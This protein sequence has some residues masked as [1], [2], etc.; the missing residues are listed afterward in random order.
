MNILDWTSLKTHNTGFLATWLRD[1]DDFG[2][3]PFEPCH[4]K[5]NN[6]VSAPHKHRRWLE[7]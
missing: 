3:K 1:I 2:A 4:E 5:N 6:V 7:A